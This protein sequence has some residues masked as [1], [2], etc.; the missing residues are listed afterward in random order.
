MVKLRRWAVLSS[1][2][3]QI[4]DDSGRMHAAKAEAPALL[5]ARRPVRS[6]TR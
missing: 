1:H 6:V 2:E 4:R 5:G 3:Q